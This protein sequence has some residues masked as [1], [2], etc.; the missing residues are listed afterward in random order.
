MKK[1]REKKPVLKV[2]GSVF[3][4]KV[5]S[6]K[7]DKTV[8]VMRILTSFVPKFERYKK[9][10][11]VIKAHNPLEINAKEGDLVRVGETRRV[12]KTKSFTVIEVLKR[13]EK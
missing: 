12:S 4:G 9:A 6:A 13:D 5:V 1:D 11:F 2:R 7:A 10:R 3:E 8:K